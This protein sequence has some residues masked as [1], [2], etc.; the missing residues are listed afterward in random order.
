VDGM[1]E[2]YLHQGRLAGY[3]SLEQVINAKDVQVEVLKVLQEKMGAERPGDELRRSLER[4]GFAVEPFQPLISGLDALQTAT[5]VPSLDAVS[6]LS[7]SPLRGIV[8]R[9]LMSGGGS[10]HLLFYLYYRGPEFSQG[11]FL[12]DLK[13]VDPSARATSPDLVS[14]QLEE[15]V[16]KSFTLAFALGGVVVLFLLISH[17]ETIRGL[18]FTLYPVVG[19]GIAMVGMMVLTGMRLNFMNAMVLVTLLGMGSDYG[20]HVMNR[21]ISR[22]EEEMTVEFVQAGRSVLLSAM[23]TI[24]GFG[25]L[26]FSDYGAL[27]SIGSA[28]NYGVGATALLA[29][30]SLPAF[31][32]V[33]NSRK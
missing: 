31:M 6:H 4:N 13:Q 5:P 27:A 25:S 10:Y 22:D 11:A 8:E 24:A 29:L 14:L 17:F 1:L 16:R 32:A 18:F 15:S 21:V 2:R 7:E 19:G 28:T 30:V 3:S 33:W 12:N 23:T 20:I 26:A 9:H